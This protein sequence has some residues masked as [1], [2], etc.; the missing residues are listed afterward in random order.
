MRASIANTEYG[1]RERCS[2]FLDRSWEAIA[3]KNGR[4]GIAARAAIQINS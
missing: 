4:T 2:H 1:V 3:K